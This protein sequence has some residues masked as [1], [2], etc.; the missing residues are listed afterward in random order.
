MNVLY[1]EKNLLYVLVNVLRFTIQKNNSFFVFSKK[2]VLT[3]NNFCFFPVLFKVQLSPLIKIDT[4]GSSASNVWCNLTWNL[5]WV[6]QK[7]KIDLDLPISFQK[8]FKI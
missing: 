7:K 4:P 3:K 8:D 2:I 5:F 6:K 1:A